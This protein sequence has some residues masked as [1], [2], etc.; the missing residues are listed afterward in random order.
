MRS[1]TLAVFMA[2][3]LCGQDV[4]NLGIFEGQTDVGNPELKGA[5]VFDAASQEYRI[6]RG[7][8]NMWEKIDQ[9]QFLW[10][11]ISGDAVITAELHF[12]QQ[13]AAAH[14]KAV[15][16]FRQALEAGAP[17]AD[18]AVHGSG[19]TALQ[20]RETANEITR[21]VQ[22]PVESPAWVRLERR[23]PW[24][25]LFTSSD[26]KTFQEAGAIQMKLVDPVY[27]G[28]GVCS[29]NPK[30]VETAVFSNVSIK[31]LPRAAAPKKK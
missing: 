26:G 18:V 1:I 31:T 14:R 29:H 22:F 15:L 6:T 21:G 8:T 16:M 2:V 20:F 28:I 25:K 17:Y 30:A 23:A 12:P 3:S 7:G 19:L 13:S 11:R 10:K 9:F 4:A 27:A 5:A 24:H